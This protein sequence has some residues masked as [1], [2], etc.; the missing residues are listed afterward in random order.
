MASRSFQ[1]CTLPCFQRSNTIKTI[2]CS[3]HKG[4]GQ[5]PVHCTQ[6]LINSMK[7]R[8]K[9]SI[10][11]LC[12]C[13][14][15]PYFINIFLEEGLY[16][17]SC[18]FQQAS[19]HD[20]SNLKHACFLEFTILFHQSILCIQTY[21]QEHGNKYYSFLIYFLHLSRHT[22]HMKHTEDT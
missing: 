14:N 17:F 18:F 5:G 2:V 4:L 8:L 19:I 6:H 13:T 3:H 20:E 22:S 7:Y 12:T 21:Q 1:Q 16:V 15:Q 9:T 11:F 10:C